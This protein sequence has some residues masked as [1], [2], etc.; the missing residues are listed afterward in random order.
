MLVVCRLTPIQLVGVDR[1]DDSLSEPE[2]P[3]WY[4]DLTSLEV[5]SAGIWAA[6]VLNWDEQPMSVTR[7]VTYRNQ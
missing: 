4:T 5:H 2:Q 3:E 7:A 6:V 1:P